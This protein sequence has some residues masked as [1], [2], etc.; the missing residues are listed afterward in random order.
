MIHCLKSN[1]NIIESMATFA[2]YCHSLQSVRL[3]H[4]DGFSECEWI[5]SVLG[6]ADRWESM[7]AAPGYI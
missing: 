2:P 7:Q 5:I 1:M 3:C 6:D 4:S